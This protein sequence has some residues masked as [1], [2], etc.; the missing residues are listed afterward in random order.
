MI[1]KKTPNPKKSS[2]KSRRVVGL[3][4]YI[5]APENENSLEKCVHFEAVNFLT[6][7][8]QS[9]QIEM[10]ALST[11]A[12]RSKDPIDHYVLSWQEGET[13]TI[14]Q[15][16]EAVQMTMKHLGLEGHQVIWGLHDDTD[17]MHVHI[18]VNR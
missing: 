2:S 14:E 1:G 5:T 18:D 6:D 11:T 15:A 4:N 12:V 13:P 17:N 7:D 10:I 8:L 16:R 9:Q 3:T